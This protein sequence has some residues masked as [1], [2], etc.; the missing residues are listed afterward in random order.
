[1]IVKDAPVL[2][3]GPRTWDAA[4]TRLRPV[5]IAVRGVHFGRYG[6]NAQHEQL[7][8]LYSGYPEL[9]H[10][11]G[12]SSFGPEECGTPG[13]IASC[14]TFKNLIGSRM[15]VANLE[16][17]A[18]LLGLFRGELDY[19][20]VP[21][22]VAAF[23]DAG[24]TWTATDRP[25]FAGGARQVVRSYGAAAR[26]NIFGVLTLEVAASRPLD[27]V[28]HGWQWQVGIRNGF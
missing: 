26:V 18:P 7:V 4:S 14:A 22:E 10:G 12:L 28:R 19:G 9:V 27:R 13:P 23:M 25:S 6:R 15:A 5:T 16:V 20:R 3:S 8:D 11:Y 24:L 2:G 1:M 21:I 17:R